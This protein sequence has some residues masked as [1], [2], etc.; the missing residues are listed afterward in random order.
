[1]RL[2]LAIFVVADVADKCLLAVVAC[3]AKYLAARDIPQGVD[4][5]EG[6]TCAVRGYELIASLGFAGDDAVN[7]VV[8]MHFFEEALA[9]MV[10]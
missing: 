9:D 1:M 6:S 10:E 3:G 5:G 4:G 2:T 7:L 8:N